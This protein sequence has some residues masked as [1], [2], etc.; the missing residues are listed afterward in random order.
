MLCV[1]TIIYIDRQPNIVD[2]FHLAQSSV[3][4]KS[5]GPLSA[6]CC[7]LAAVTL[8]GMD[9]R[10]D[11]V[12]AYLLAGIYRFF[13]ILPGSMDAR[14]AALSISYGTL[15]HDDGRQPKS[16]EIV[17][18]PHSCCQHHWLHI[19]DIKVYVCNGNFDQAPPASFQVRVM[20]YLHALN[21][22]TQL[23]VRALFNS[24]FCSMHA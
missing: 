1:E 11:W 23:C 14:A 4:M 2:Q 17:I 8:A 13:F 16:V 7:L 10:L 3:T 15:I 6:Q 18:S 5:V 24:R 22:C 19:D 12:P 21:N 9:T 20:P